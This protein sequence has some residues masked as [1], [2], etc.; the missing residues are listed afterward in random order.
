MQLGFA[1]SWE[2]QLL[3]WKVGLPLPLVGCDGSLGRAE[4]GLGLHPAN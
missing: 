2:S 3:Q 4:L 1:Q